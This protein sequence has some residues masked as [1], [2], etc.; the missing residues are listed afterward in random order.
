MGVVGGGRGALLEVVLLADMVEGLLRNF[1][2]ADVDDMEE[3]FVV[4]D[5]VVVVVVD[6]VIVM[7]G[8]FISQIA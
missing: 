5:A 7:T 6:V 8:T 1:G 4:P 2:S 3:L